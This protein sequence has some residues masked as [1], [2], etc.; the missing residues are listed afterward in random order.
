MEPTIDEGSL[1]MIDQSQHDI[2]DGLVALVYNGDAYIKRI[3]KDLGD[4]HV[5]SD[6]PAYSKKNPLG[7]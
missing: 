7:P 3:Q 1:V 2:T 4:V 6:N 5:I